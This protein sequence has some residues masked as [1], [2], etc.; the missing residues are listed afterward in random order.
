MKKRILFLLM[1]S[2]LVMGM[3][4]MIANAATLP[5][6]DVSASEWYYNDVKL[7]Y[8]AGLINGK[9]NDVFAPN[10]NLTYAEAAKLAA[11]MHQRKTGKPT[12][13]MQ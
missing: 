5:F 8:E 6:K 10:D 12:I 7:A 13:V 2:A 3:L 1:A 9:S 11:C 4:P